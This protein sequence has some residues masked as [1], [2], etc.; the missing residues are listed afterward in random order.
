VQRLA[1]SDDLPCF[2][3]CSFLWYVCP[4]QRNA[5]QPRFRGLLTVQRPTYN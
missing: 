1:T 5:T 3:R 4:P 2:V